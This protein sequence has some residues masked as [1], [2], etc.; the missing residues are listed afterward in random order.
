MF[1]AKYVQRG[2]TID[3]IPAV[4]VNAGDVVQVGTIVGIAKLDIKAGALGALAIVGAYDFVKGT[5]A[6]AFGAALYWDGEKATTAQT[7]IYLGIAIAAAKSEDGTV[8]AV[9]NVGAAGDGDDSSSA[10]ESSSPAAQAIRSNEG[11]TNG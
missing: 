2:E 11:M 9:I 10:S 5:G 3:Y 6:I 7:D 1:K 8:R 4:D